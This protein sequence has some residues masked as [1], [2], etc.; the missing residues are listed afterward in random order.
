MPLV[1]V[2]GAYRG[3]NDAEPLDDVDVTTVTE[4]VRLARKMKMPLAFC[5]AVRKDGSFARGVWLPDCRPKVT[6]SVFDHPE[7]SAFQNREFLNVFTKITARE[8]YA[9]GPRNDSSMGATVRQSMGT[10]R[11]MRIVMPAHPLQKCSTM[12]GMA[13]PVHRFVA[14]FDLDRDIQFAEW[15]ASI[16]RFQQ[17]DGPTKQQAAT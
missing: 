5:R 8:I 14:N 4:S 13:A 12:R 10:D 17:M 16:C 15:A 9:V 3:F 11:A 7:G 1:V 6:D 2:F